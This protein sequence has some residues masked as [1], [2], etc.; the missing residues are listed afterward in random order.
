MNVQ[1]ILEGIAAGDRR[2][3]ARAITMVENE[4]EG[5]N[6]LLLS[7][8]GISTPVTGITGP[9]GA[10]KSSLIG[11]MLK[12]LCAKKNEKGNPVQIAVLAVDPTSPFSHGSFLGDRLR[13][14]EHFNNPQIYIRSLATRGALGGLSA[15]IVEIV[16]VIRAAEFDYILIETVGVG[17]SE[18]E[19]VSLADTTI[20][21]L[22]PEAGDEIQA[23]KSGIME[24]ADIFVVNKSD[25][26]GADRFAAGLI[27]TLHERPNNEQWNVAVV[28]T[29]A[30]RNIGITELL[31]TIFQHHQKVPHSKNKK[32]LAERAYRL[33]QQ[34]KMRTIS[35]HDI[36]KKLA[37]EMNKSDFNLYSFAQK[38]Y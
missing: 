36:E 4:L 22:V 9:P 1:K 18:I 33:I 26:E 34:E 20:V 38:F 37:A 25:R 27:K 21:V 13:M 35:I 8:P 3:L 19:I 14:Q 24:I 10:G 17:Q 32:L 16:D 12:E 15:K 2:I 7:L 28:K 5:F 11:A 6:E 30:T 23:I 31:N 29:A